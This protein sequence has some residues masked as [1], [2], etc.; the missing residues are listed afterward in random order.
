[1]IRPARY[2]VPVVGPQ[3]LT[4]TGDDVPVWVDLESPDAW[5]VAGGLARSAGHEKD[6]ARPGSCHT[7][8]SDR[9]AAA[10]SACSKSA[11]GASGGQSAPPRRR[12]YRVKRFEVP[13][14]RRRVHDERA[15]LPQRGNDL[16]PL[17]GR[18]APALLRAA[19]LGSPTRADHQRRARRVGV[20]RS[21]RPATPRSPRRSAAR[22]WLR[23]RTRSEGASIEPPGPIIGSPARHG[24]PPLRKGWTPLSLRARRYR[25]PEPCR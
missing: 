15:S 13:R 25:R 8:R 5:R 20:S 24:I 7:G 14:V 4:L 11:G 23:S 19:T 6:A 1:M 9:P 2:P 21:L 18:S 16:L 10:D 12:H 3:L 17:R 22:R